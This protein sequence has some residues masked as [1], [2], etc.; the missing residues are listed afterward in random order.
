MAISEQCQKCENTPGSYKCIE[1]IEP[2]ED[3]CQN[4]A[5]EN[6]SCN[7]I[8]TTNY[9]CICFD[10]YVVFD[11]SNIT[12]RSRDCREDPCAQNQFCK[13]I[14][15]TFECAIF[16]PC[17]IN[18]GGCSHTCTI[19]P[20]NSS[21]PICKCPENQIILED[22]KSCGC[23]I[24]TV[25]NDNQYCQTISDCSVN[26]GN[27]EQICEDSQSGSK[28]LCFEGFTSYN[29]THCE[30]IDECIQN[31]TCQQECLNSIGSFECKCLEGYF[32]NDKQ[33]CEDINE[34]D[35]S[36]QC[37]YNCTNLLGS[38][39]CHCPKDFELNEDG[40]TCN[41]VYEPCDT[42]V[43]IEHGILNCN[44]NEEFLQCEVLC[45]NGYLLRGSELNVC[46]DGKWNHDFAQCVRKFVFKYVYYFEF[47][48][49][50]LIFS[51]FMS[52]PIETTIRYNTTVKVCIWNKF[53]WREVYS[54]LLSWIYS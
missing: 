27:C 17:E 37:Q 39:K 29:L 47:E 36:S 12:C 41:R 51:N 52:F 49:V 18:R 38:F 45:N 22:N 32:L 10:G 13:Q 35:I 43:S 16:D 14:D 24:N 7:K 26:N 21:N 3:P 15:D 4:H 28:C 25:L 46:N 42:P 2:F 9:E 40:L 23:P 34:C 33:E 53:S 8:S 5:C 50:L 48:F 6:A 44:K 19:D 30:D 20:L 1:N 11:N 31:N 54:T